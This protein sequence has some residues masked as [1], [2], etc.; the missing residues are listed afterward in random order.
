M[1][2]WPVFEHVPFFGLKKYFSEQSLLMK[3]NVIGLDVFFLKFI[4]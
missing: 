2:K 1:K 4:S 3:R